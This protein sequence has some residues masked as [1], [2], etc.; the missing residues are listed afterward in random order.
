MPQYGIYSRFYTEEDSAILTSLLD[1]KKIPYEIEREINQ[2]DTIYLGES[3]D[4]MVVVKLPK[5]QFGQV[6]ELLATQAKIDFDKPDFTHYLVSYEISELEEIARN[7]NEWNGYDL[8]ITELL[9]QKNHTAAPGSKSSLKFITSYR[10]ERIETKWIVLGYL[11]CFLTIVGIF[12][13]LAIIQAKKTLQN[14]ETV[15]IYD[16]TTLAHGYRMIVIG[17]MLT[18]F[19]VLSKLA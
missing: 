19:V 11:L 12:F 6:T 13:G 3:L 5:N 4:P 18:A 8:Q 16:K 2:L 10:P 17:G 14:G 7:P 15:N 1:Q 9:L